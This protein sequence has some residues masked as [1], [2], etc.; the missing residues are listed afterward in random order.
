MAGP[1]RSDLAD[2]AEIE[3]VTL[4]TDPDHQAPAARPS[5]R[6]D[7]AVGGMH[8]RSCVALIEET[9]VEQP[10]VVRASVDLDSALATVEYD[11]ALVDVAGLCHLVVEAGYQAEP[12][13]SA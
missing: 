3:L 10:G 12:A 11:P 7:L 6:T 9:L 1:V 2:R 4:S 8:C 13:A 5:A